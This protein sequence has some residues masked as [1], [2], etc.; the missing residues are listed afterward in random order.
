MRLSELARAVGGRVEGRDVEVGGVTHDSRRVRPGDIFVAIAGR[1]ADGTR[2]VPQALASGAVAVC[3]SEPLPGTPTLVVSDPRRTLALLAGEIHGHPDR[4]LHLIGVT[5]SLGKTSTTL[6][7]R[8]A[9]EAGGH[10][11]GL[12]GSLGIHFGERIVET[13]MTTPE[14]PAIHGALRRMVA[15]GA[16]TAVM[17]VTSHSIL[18]ERVAGLEFALGVLTNLVADEHLEFHP[19]P[20]HYLQTKARFFDMLAPGA[21][22]LANLDDPIG[23]ERVRKLGRPVIGVSAEGAPD[24]AIEVSD[25]SMS[26]HGSRFRLRIR[27]PLPTIEGGTVAPTEV[28]VR[29]PILGLQQVE[30]AALALGA[31]IVAGVPP[32]DAAAALARAEPMRRRMEIVREDDPAILDD[33]V[34]NPL[35]VRAVFDAIRGIPCDGV[36]VLYALRGTRGETINRRN[37]RAIA[38]GARSV[39]AS[40]VVSASD[41]VADERNRVTAEERDAALAELDA[42][43]VEYA[44][45]PGL[46]DAVRRTL[47]GTRQET[48]VLLLGAQG[49]DRGAELARE[50]LAAQ[51]R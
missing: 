28:E 26:V 22:L 46:R 39:G 41:D 19:T 40:L 14:A 45:E 20:E 36:R 38:E 30:N 13:G 18:L 42:L 37:A 12:I 21:P 33:T 17:E 3:A 44:F 24:A 2:F 9:L 51:G 25:V 29:M 43:G 23:G 49:M 5:G 4:S 34:G 47:E 8:T 16:T 11:V 7:A 48:L 1:Q 10:E 35:S 31:A 32:A 27:R 6:L 15:E 50:A